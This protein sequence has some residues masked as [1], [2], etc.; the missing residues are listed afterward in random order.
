VSAT[1]APTAGQA[2]VSDPSSEGAGGYSLLAASPAVAPEDADFLAYRPQISDHLHLGLVSGPQLAFHRLPSGAWAYSRRFVGGRRRG[3]YR[4]VVHT[5]VL[6]RAALAAIAEDVWLLVGRAGVRAPGRSEP[7]PLSDL[8]AA[9]SDPA[10]RRLDDLE[11]VP[12]REPVRVRR[13]VLRQRLAALADHWGREAL[14]DRLARTLAAV[15]AGRRLLL[16]QGSEGEN[17]LALAWQALPVRDRL[18]TGWTTH[19]GPGVGDLYRLANALRPAE[20]RGELSAADEWLLAGETTVDER[21]GSRELADALVA[22]PE[23]ID[24][25]YDGFRDLGLSLLE[26][27]ARLRRWVAAGSALA[28]DGFASVGEL[29]AALARLRVAPGERL[30]APDVGPAAVLATAAAT[31][32]RQVEAGLPLRDAAE[33]VIDALRASHLLAEATAP[34]V[35]AETARRRAARGDRGTAVAAVALALRTL[36]GTPG[37]TADADLLTPLL[38]ADPGPGDTLFRGVL[39]ALALRLAEA[40]PAA[41][42]SA[43][44][45]LAAEPGWLGLLRGADR[46]RP[47]GPGAAVAALRA[48]RGAGDREAAADLLRA[49]LLP[50]LAPI[51]E[52]APDDR[53]VV[54]GALADNAAADELVEAVRDW[55]GEPRAAA[56]GALRSALAGRPEIGRA[57]VAAL[58][59]EPRATLAGSPAVAGLTAAAIG[60]GVPAADWVPLALA[61]AAFAEARGGPAGDALRDAIETAPAPDAGEL[62]AAGE[63]LTEGLRRLAPG[64]APG[65]LHRALV[66]RMLPALTARPELAAPALGSLERLPGDELDAWAPVVEEL[67]GLLAGAGRAAE[68]SAVRRVWWSAAVDRIGE[69]SLSD[70]V[71]ALAGGLAPDDAGH[72]ALRL[73][74]RLRRL[75]ADPRI[76]AVV[77]AVRRAAPAGARWEV[78]LSALERE[79]RLGRLALPAALGRAE[80]AL[81][82][83]GPAGA[84]LSDAFR[85]LFPGEPGPRVAAIAE[86]LL[87]AEVRP[88]GKR[89]LEANELDEALRLAG[90]RVFDA[91]PSF[92]RLAGRGTLLLAAAAALGARWS[93]DPERSTAWVR[94]ALAME[95]YDFL[96]VYLLASERGGRRRGFLAGAVRRGEHALLRDLRRARRSALA[97]WALAPYGETL[98]E[99]A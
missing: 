24:A 25:L 21:G 99:A 66:G 68:A 38:V 27:G 6:D 35:A 61:E 98:D 2:V 9:L 33:D 84:R 3:A 86:A 88:T 52:L 97:T 90:S 93:D 11:L 31:L 34:A 30:D 32:R 46:A 5:L 75:P 39:R 59:A 47:L 71:L 69:L 77:D 49:D 89:W 60:A 55:Q 53:A 57:A 56:L 20:A 62:A 58:A 43:F 19:L 1:G 72:V 96:A 40:D 64:V 81:G 74:P 45:R 78:E 44:E 70:A 12:P 36:H 28:V 76:D 26:D 29:A 91:L 73:G 65:P 95:R 42:A 41:A 80:E 4:I 82:R 17:L 15:E 50:G 10:L 85:R 92:E 7:M 87:S 79:V 67:A 83:S 48:A 16:A 23:G 13:H 51:A 94:R 22:R 8:D 63:R 14:A 37:S 18:A 54:A